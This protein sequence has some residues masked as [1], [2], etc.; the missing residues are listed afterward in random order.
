MPKQIVKYPFKIHALETV[1]E[2]QP[3][4]NGTYYATEEEA[5]ERCHEYLQAPGQHT[6]GFVIFKA[7][8]VVR[9]EARPVRV[10]RINEDGSIGETEIV[11]DMDFLRLQGGDDDEG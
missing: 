7:H 4:S 6:A 2:C 8:V 11:D 3:Y 1:E 10:N 9:P 5:L